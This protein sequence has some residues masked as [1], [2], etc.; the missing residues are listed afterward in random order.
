MEKVLTELVG[1]KIDINCGTTAFRGESVGYSD[2][3][4]RIRDDYDKVIF[5]ESSKIV[6]VSEVSDASSRPG[7]IG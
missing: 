4:L 2:G 1:K 7:F 3:V 6:A 5:I